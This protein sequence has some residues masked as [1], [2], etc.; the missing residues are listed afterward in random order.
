MPDDKRLPKNIKNPALW[1]KVRAEARS[2][3]D[4][5]PTA[6]ASG[7]V[8]GQYE[9]RGGTYIGGGKKDDGEK[10]TKAAPKQ[11]A[12]AADDDDDIPF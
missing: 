4:P 2:K 11:Q 3:F 10:P 12:A 5:W 8:A 1:R 9:S 7:W 6:F